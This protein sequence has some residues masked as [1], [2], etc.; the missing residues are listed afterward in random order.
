[1]KCDAEILGMNSDRCSIE[2]VRKDS[3]IGN[4]GKKTLL[5]LATIV[6]AGCQTTSPNLPDLLKP[7]KLQPRTE[8]VERRSFGHYRVEIYGTEDARLVITQR[9]KT[10]FTR[11]GT[12]FGVGNRPYQEYF[13]IEGVQAPSGPIPMGTDITGNSI[14]NVMIH[15]RADAARGG[16]RFHLFEIGRRFR[17][18][19]TLGYGGDDYGDFQDITG[20]GV[21]E[22]LTRDDSFAGFPGYS[23]AETLLPPVIQKYRDGQYRTD[24]ELMRK[25]PPSE[26]ELQQK[27][28]K[29]RS[30]EWAHQEYGIP[31][32]YPMNGLNLIYSGNLDSAQIFFRQA[33]PEGFEITADLQRKTL[34][35][36]LQSSPYYQDLLRL[37]DVDGF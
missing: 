14:P 32:D 12:F 6:F 31:F 36:F 30:Q 2:V 33:V 18:V 1:M 29:V 25:P 10:V 17:F 21:F 27:I 5:F 28:T 26:S 16:H 35:E 24:I 13:H 9:G 22:F 8:L 34:F 20:D 11:D 37:N 7:N 19:Q 15:E 23:R 4:K 3:V